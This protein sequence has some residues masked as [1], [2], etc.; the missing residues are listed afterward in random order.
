MMMLEVMNGCCFDHAEPFIYKKSES[1]KELKK[2]AAYLQSL[3]KK[4][5]EKS[6]IYND[7]YITDIRIVADKYPV[8]VLYQARS[9]EYISQL[10]DDAVPTWEQL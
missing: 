8:E 1:F 9:K 2:T 6:N 5:M 7:V 3:S 10:N 4:E